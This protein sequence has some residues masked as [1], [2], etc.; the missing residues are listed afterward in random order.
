[1][2]QQLK[3]SRGFYQ[4]KAHTGSH[5]HTN[6]ILMGPES[7]LFHFSTNV[8]P[9]SWYLKKIQ[10]F[11]I[12]FGKKLL[13]TQLFICHKTHQTHPHARIQNHAQNQKRK[14]R[15]KL[16]IVGR[17]LSCYSGNIFVF[18]SKAMPMLIISQ[19]EQTNSVAVIKERIEFENGKQQS[20]HV[21]L[22]AHAEFIASIQY[23]H[24]HR[25]HIMAFFSQNIRCK[26][27]YREN[28][29]H[30]LSY[31]LFKTINKFPF[32]FILVCIC[33]ILKWRM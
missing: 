16:N 27:L 26:L 13:F 5:A 33:S 31:L 18:F 28:K 11:P 9:A 32:Y 10:F 30:Y 4:T 24:R 14:E 7:N 25:H 20:N 8:Q 6:W 2:Q 3:C 12:L 21:N 19:I 1:M 15:G 22:R 29:D 17:E 23:Y